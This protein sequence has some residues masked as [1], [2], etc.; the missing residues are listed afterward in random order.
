MV[1]ICCGG[2]RLE[3]FQAGQVADASSAFEVG[4]QGARTGMNDAH[5]EV[6]RQLAGEIIARKGGRIAAKGGDFLVKTAGHGMAAQGDDFCPRGAECAGALGFQDGNLLLHFGHA[7][8]G[9]R[10]DVGDLLLGLCPNS[11]HQGGR[12]R[13]HLTP[14]LLLDQGAL[15]LA[16][17]HCG[18]F[19]PR[20]WR[21]FLLNGDKGFFNRR[22]RISGIIMCRIN[23]D[24]TLRFFC[25]PIRMNSVL[26]LS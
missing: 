21:L 23:A 14:P 25:L 12:F 18:A 13:L 2:S 24:S 11:R 5:R 7:Q 9:V 6:I 17:R 15:T 3:N 16:P 1:V 4:P 22:Q 20:L 8:P 19:L 10:L 26:K